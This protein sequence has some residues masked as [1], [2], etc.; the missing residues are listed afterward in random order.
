MN[1]WFF[2][3]IQIPKTVKVQISK[4]LF[5]KTYFLLVKSSEGE[6]CSISLV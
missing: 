1:N 3:K 5:Q 4:I 6:N 2:L